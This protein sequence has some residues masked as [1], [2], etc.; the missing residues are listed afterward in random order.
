M[1]ILKSIFQSP[2]GKTKAAVIAAVKAGYRF[3]DCA[4]DYD[5]GEVVDDDAVVERVNK[6]GMALTA[7]WVPPT[8]TLTP[9]LHSTLGCS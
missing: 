9:L 1:S 3:I 6:C 7:Y 4:N 2:P 8:T 5:N